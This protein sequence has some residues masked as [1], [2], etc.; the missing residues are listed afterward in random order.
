MTL[1]TMRTPPYIEDSAAQTAA[2]RLE[3]V[4][5]IQYKQAAK[6]I[7]LRLILAVKYKTPA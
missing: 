2:A 4:F 3:N 5:I 6:T 1:S 7:F